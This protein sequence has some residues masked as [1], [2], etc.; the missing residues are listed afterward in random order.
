MVL[1]T[2]PFKA[3]RFPV[4]AAGSQEWGLALVRAI[5][6]NNE[7][8]F[9]PGS[10]QRVSGFI[11]QFAHRRRHRR[12]LARPQHPDPA[13]RHV[14]RRA[15]PRRGRRAYARE[16]EGRAG[17]DVKLV[18]RDAVTLDFTLNPDFSQVESDEPQVTVNQR[19]EVFFPGE[20]AVLPRELR[21]LQTRR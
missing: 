2:V 7:T 20:A 12:R 16:N 1:I 13:L 9:W 18:P 11:A 17:V 4:K 8:D 15:L 6:S 19:F 14:H 21:L 3:L 5:R 10:T